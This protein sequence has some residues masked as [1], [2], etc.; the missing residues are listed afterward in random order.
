MIQKDPRRSGWEQRAQ[1]V[2]MLMV[3]VLLLLLLLQLWLITIAL[4]EYLAARS[5][6][7]LPTFLASGFCFVLN[8]ILLKYLY[9]ID[10][11]KG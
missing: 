11:R 5:D 7:A 6:L 8:L 1:A 3:F 4:E 2:T 10:R 9:G